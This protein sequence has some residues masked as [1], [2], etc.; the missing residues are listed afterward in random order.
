MV[1]FALSIEVE[2][3][4]ECDIASVGV[5]ALMV[6]TGVFVGGCTVSV[7]GSMEATGA[8]EG[9]SVTAA[10]G[11]ES[12]GRE[13]AIINK[14]TLNKPVSFRFNVFINLF[15]ERTAYANIQAAIGW[16]EFETRIHAAVFTISTESAPAAAAGDAFSAFIRIFPTIGGIIRISF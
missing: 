14:I 16:I 8:S 3:T 6:G 2:G 5:T 9:T 10:G 13:Q 1:N 11:V 12:P 15:C 4:S 7:A